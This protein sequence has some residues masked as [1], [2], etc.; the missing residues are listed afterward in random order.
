MPVKLHNDMLTKQFLLATQKPGHVN[1]TDLERPPSP[2][3][4]QMVQT[5]VSRYGANIKAITTAPRSTSRPMRG[6]RKPSITTEVAKAIRQQNLEPNKILQ[7]TP[8]IVNP[9]E[10]KLN[11][12]VRCKLSQLR[13]GHSTLLQS[14]WSAIRKDLTLNV[15]P[16][17]NATPYDTLLMFNCPTRQ[18]PEGLTARSLWEQPR[19]ACWTKTTTTD[20]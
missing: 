6:T 20:R 8:P 18:N 2:P 1:A 19:S 5:L 13:S 17:C 15:C 10:R 4:R 9:E 14:Y 3:G 11:R 16:D 7:C 12:N